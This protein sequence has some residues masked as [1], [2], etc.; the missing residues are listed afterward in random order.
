MTLLVAADSFLFLLVGWALVG[1]ASFLL[2]GFWYTRP[3]AVAAAKKAFVVN[4]IGDFGLMLAIFLLFDRFGTLAYQPI[5]SSQ[6]W[7]ANVCPAGGACGLPNTP[8]VSVGLATAIAL[9][10]LVA[11]AA[12]S[13]QLPLHVWLPDA[14][15]GPTPVSALIHAATMVTAGVYLVARAAPIFSSSPQALAVVGGVGGV[16]AIFAAIIACVQTDIKR[17]LAYSTMSQLGYMF[18]GEAAGGYTFGIF[19]LTT[20]AY[21]KALLFMGAGAV[22]HALAGEQDMRKMG[23]LRQRM[24]ATFWS[25]VIGGAALAAIFPFSGFWSKDGILGIVLERG[26]HGGGG[27]WF[28]LYGIGLLTAVLTGFYIFRLI[29]L[30]F[31]GT[32]RGGEIAAGQGGH[33]TATHHTA[34][35]HTVADARRDMG[36]R[37][38]LAGLRHVGWAMLV[39]MGVLALLSVIGGFEGTPFGDAFSA[40]LAP[41]LP[42]PNT[43]PVGGGLF[44]LAF[45]VGLVTGPIGIAMAWARYGRGQASFTQSRNPLVILLEHKFYIDELYDHAIVRPLIWVGGQLRRGFEDVTLDGG[46]RGVGRVIGWASGGFRA[47]QTGYTRNYALAIFVGAALMVLY[48]AT[49]R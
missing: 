39:P 16:T 28:V 17:V 9:L 43:L 12:K 29:F 5:L 48:Y 1:L 32:Y 25:F 24:P 6:G 20:H 40:F 3:A 7:L 45:A 13:A 47:L 15:E 30:V 22:I 27:G 11:A 18:M 26:L 4:V 46:S 31:F 8:L 41:V 2:I 34:T 10:L 37:D 35:H 36:R 23:G 14:M 49:R 42:G 19:H 38:P 33:E 44:W 21:F